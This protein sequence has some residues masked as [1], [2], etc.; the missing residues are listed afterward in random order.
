[1]KTGVKVLILIGIIILVIVG[2][3]VGSRIWLNYSW[4]GKLGFL[5]VFTK[6]L[7]TRLGLWWGFFFL[8]LLFG[9]Y[10]MIVAF[11]KGNIQSM[12]IQQA[13]V[14]VEI[15]RTVGIVIASVGLF[16]LALI[17]AGNAVGRW[18]MI[19]RF[20]NR[21]EFGTAD[22]IFGRDI[23][24]YVFTLPLWLFLKGWWLG[25]IILTI[26]AVG[27]LYLL[28]GNVTLDQ[29][30]LVMSNQAKR[31]IIFLLFLITLIIIWNYWLNV[32]QLNY[33]T[34]GVI[35]G[36][37]YTDLHVTRY[38][39]YVMMAVTA[40]VA[41]YI[42]AGMKRA[43]FKQP[44]VGFGVLIG[45]AIVI[46]GIIPGVVQGISVKPNELVRETPYIENNIAFTQRGFGLDRIDE[47]EF[48]VED[49]LTAE[50][51][52][53]ETG[54]TKNVRL[55]DHRPLKSTFAQIQEFRLY[56]NFNDV[57]VDRYTFDGELR[58]VMLSAREINYQQIPPEAQTWVNRRLQFTHGYGL[59]MAPV[60]EIGPEGLPV[61]IVKNIP[62]EMSVPLELDRPEIYYGEQSSD[63]VIVNTELA[64]FDYPEGDRNVTVRYAGTGGLPVGNAFRKFLFALQLRSFEII[65]TGYLNPD[66]RV[67]LNR[68][69]QDRVPKLAPFLRYD[70]NPY[71]VVSGGRLYWIL[72]AY[73][74]SDKYPYST[75]HRDRHNY[76]RNSVKITVDAYT[77]DVSY[78]IIDQ[79]DPVIRT[80][81]KAFPG[82]FEDFADMPDDLQRHI[83][84]PLYLFD[85]Q[86]SIYTTYHMSE[87]TVFYNKEDQWNIPREIYGEEQTDMIPYYTIVQFPEDQG[88]EEFV[89]MLPFTPVNKNNMVAW[90]GAL[91]DPEN[92]G[93]LVLYQFPKQKLVFGPLQIESRIDQN[94]EISQLFTLWGQRGSAIIRGNLLVI[95]VRDS[96][97]Y[98]EPVYLRAEQSELPEMR[99]VIV[100][101]QDRIEIGLNLREALAKVFGVWEPEEMR[102]VTAEG[103]P[104]LIDVRSL[105][106]DAVRLYDQAQQRLREGDFAGYG[107]AIEDLRGVLSD[108]ERNVE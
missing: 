76:I 3:F 51:F 72:D 14:P 83:R 44:L 88:R 102:E 4:F 106:I 53:P 86:A 87:P 96:L 61:L 45:A 90:L 5:N 13:G 30:R 41:V 59:V 32:Y 55:W 47:R 25:T 2:L 54:I 10:N 67:M 22:P 18:D 97:I 49:S 99:R 74:T 62:P 11:K 23:S 63:Y 98:V 91:C 9:G 43:S 57:D 35:F 95:P 48:P 38:A 101:Y 73:T 71:L 17:M 36:A 85:M 82:M 92:Y 84:Y 64:E 7:W 108:M 40:F 100:G 68:S 104:L 39:Y 78:Y 16:I 37:G 15:S 81:D 80:Y 60:N 31:H 77:G 93:E 56:Y 34:R 79:E 75:P 69:I 65:F 103:V 8:F 107:R 66:S 105:V 42:L 52:R 89:L 20:A 29:N 50:T 19:L 27:F 24:F 26:I 33:S 1:M 70:P 6:L 12:K 28:S 94:S 46:T 21:T 58:Q